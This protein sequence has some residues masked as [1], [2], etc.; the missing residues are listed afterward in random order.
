MSNL[1]Q[2]LDAT[3][4]ASAAAAAARAAHQERTN[5]LWKLLAPVILSFDKHIRPLFES[6]GQEELYQER[7]GRAEGSQLLGL[8]PG[9][10][11]LEVLVGYRFRCDMVEN[12]FRLPLVYLTA[13]PQVKLEADVEHYTTALARLTRRTE[14]REAREKRDA[15][16]REFAR[17]K[18]LLGNEPEANNG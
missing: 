13:D 9:K 17:L 1:Q 2:A 11:F 16:M 7:F 4:A 6:A 14:A 8:Y 5:E 18:E 10:N 12:T 15:D 3:Y